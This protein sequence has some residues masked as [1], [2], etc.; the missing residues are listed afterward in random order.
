MFYILYRNF[1]KKKCNEIFIITSWLYC[2]FGEFFCP[3]YHLAYIQVILTTVI[4]YDSSKKFILLFVP[5]A[6]SLYLYTFSILN[7]KLEEE[8]IVY[9]NYFLDIQFSIISVSVFSIILYIIMEKMRKEKEFMESKF[10]N[11]GNQAANIL[12]DIKNQI[13]PPLNYA[14]MLMSEDF[15]E[16]HQEISQELNKSLLGIKDYVQEVGSLVSFKNEKENINLHDIISKYKLIFES[17]LKNIEITVDQDDS[18]FCNTFSNFKGVVYNLITNSVQA[19]SENNNSDKKIKIKIN[20]NYFEYEDSAGGIPLT[21]LE[22]LKNQNY[23][24]SKKEGTGLGFYFIHKYVE[25]YNLKLEIN[26]KNQGMYV[27]IVFKEK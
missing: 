9:K 16:S 25:Q 14:K 26:N 6:S 15:K 20:K 13:V 1:Y 4:V 24:S 22:S 12:H 27:K 19:F 11:L 23:T 2:V 8:T 21:I 10:M 5:I 7:I 17:K 3:G 18:V